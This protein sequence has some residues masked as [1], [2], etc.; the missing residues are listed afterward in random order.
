MSLIGLQYVY[1][2][3]KDDP[4]KD[5]DDLVVEMCNKTWH[6]FKENVFT[7][8]IASGVRIRLITVSSLSK[9]VHT[10][11]CGSDIQKQ[12]L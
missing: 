7:A 12:R 1:E 8:W 5:F 3:V 10:Q 9:Q 4:S 2:E 11:R 6:S